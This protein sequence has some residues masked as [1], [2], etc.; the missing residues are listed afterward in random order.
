MWRATDQVLKRRVAVKVMRE[1]LSAPDAVT[2]FE[3]E[4]LIAGRLQHPGITVMFDSGSHDGKLFIVMEF[5]DGQDLAR[6]LA[7][8]PDGLPVGE[9]VALVIQAADAL[10]AAHEHGVVHRDLKPGN[11]FVQRSGSLKLCDFGIAWAAGLAAGLTLPDTALGTAPN[12]AP[13]QW[14]GQRADERSDLYSLGC[15]L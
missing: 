5:L 13:E 10:Q 1:R 14:G 2:R 12:M 15:V 7:R 8:H 9:A 6:V 11:M 3:R 4:A